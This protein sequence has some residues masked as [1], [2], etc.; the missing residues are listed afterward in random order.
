MNTIVFNMV[1]LKHKYNGLL[2]LNVARK[3]QIKKI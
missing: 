3:T 2:A 1:K